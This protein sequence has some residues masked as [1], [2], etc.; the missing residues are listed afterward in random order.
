MMF[1]FFSI[2]PFVSSLSIPMFPGY[3]AYI[4]KYMLQVICFIL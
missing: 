1:I 3:V 4:N 2:V